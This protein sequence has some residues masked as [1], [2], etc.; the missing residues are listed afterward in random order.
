[1]QCS[2]RTKGVGV[3]AEERWDTVDDGDLADAYSPPVRVAR[4]VHA[5]ILSR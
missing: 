3:E 1:M 4:V 5:V 2:E